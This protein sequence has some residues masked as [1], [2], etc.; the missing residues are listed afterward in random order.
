MLLTPEQADE[1]FDKG[2]GNRKKR[3]AVK[4]TYWS[5]GIIPY[6]FTANTFSSADKSQ[7]Y[8]AMR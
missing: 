8:A 2:E 4:R 7:I 3:A 5:K 6:S 1:L